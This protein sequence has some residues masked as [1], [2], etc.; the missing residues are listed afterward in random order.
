MTISIT[1]HEQSALMIKAGDKNLAIDFGTLTPT[2]RLAHL[3][4]PNATLVSHQHGDHF[5]SEHLRAFGAPV[6]GPQDVIS[7]LP[8]DLTTTVLR[9]GETLDVAG[10]TV[11]P[12]EVDH[13]PKLSVPIEN[14]GFVIDCPDGH[15]IFFAGDIARPGVLPEGTFDTVVLPVGGAGFVFDASQAH[16]YLKQIGHQGNVIPVH[17]TGPADRGA[18]DRFVHLAPSHLNVLALGVGDSTEVSP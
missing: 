11:T 2:E 10:F 17:D 4:K 1:R 3:P 15:A 13:G 8:E 16:D 12:I 14:L 6:F 9:A 7:Q 5:A 18:V